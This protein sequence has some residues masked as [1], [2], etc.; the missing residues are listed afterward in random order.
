MSSNSPMPGMF[1]PSKSGLLS[2]MKGLEKISADLKNER[3]KS[4]QAL[5]DRARL[6]I[7][8]QSLKKRMETTLNELDESNRNNRN[9]EED[10]SMLKGRISE[11]E[12]SL[13]T[14]KKELS[15]ME[16][17]ARE[18]S[19]RIDEEVK[20][21]G[22]LET[23]AEQCRVEWRKAQIASEEYE[24]RLQQNQSM[25][26]ELQAELERAIRLRDMSEQKYEHVNTIV[27]DQAREMNQLSSQMAVNAK[28]ATD[29]AHMKRSNDDLKNELK[30]S[31]EKSVLQ[32]NQIHSLSAELNELKNTEGLLN[33]Q[34]LSL[35]LEK[36]KIVQ[37]HRSSE[38]AF[39]EMEKRLKAELDA[40]TA[41]SIRADS[42]I[43]SRNALENQVD[44]LKFAHDAVLETRNRLETDLGAKNK[45]ENS[46]REELQEAKERVMKLE[47][48]LQE[49]EGSQQLS[50]EV[51][52]LRAQLTDLRR[53]LT[54]REVEDEASHITPSTFVEREEQ[55]RRMYEGIISDLRGEVERVA[56]AHQNT[57]TKLE[58]ASRKAALCDQL[59]EQVQIYKE[60]AKMSAVETY[61]V[62][63]TASEAQ[64][65]SQR[66]AHEKEASQ[67]ELRTTKSE[68]VA[69]RAE[70]VR[71]RDELL[72]ER[73]VTRDRQLE[74][75]SSER[76][77]A[78]LIAVKSRLET[79]L[80]S[81]SQDLSRLASANDVL[82]S[83][84]RELEVSLS[85]AKSNLARANQFKSEYSSLNERFAKLE[86]E[87]K[88][89]ESY[90]TA[91]LN[92]LNQT[93]A[94]LTKELE[95]AQNTTHALRISLDD[96]NVT[97][98]GLRVNLGDTRR[99]RDTLTKSVGE[100]ERS[101]A[102]QQ[103]SSLRADLSAT[104]TS[105][106]NAE[107]MRLEKDKAMHN[108]RQEI[109]REK[110]RSGLLKSQVNLLENRLRTCLQELGVYRTLDVYQSGLN[111]EMTRNNYT[112]DSYSPNRSYS[113][114][115]RDRRRAVSL[116][117]SRSDDPEL[118]GLQS[119]LAA[120]ENKEYTLS[121]I[122]AYNE[123][124]NDNNNNNNSSGDT[125]G[126]HHSTS[127][128]KK[129]KI[130]NEDDELTIYDLHLEE[131][132]T[133]TNT[134]NNGDT[135]N[136]SNIDQKKRRESAASRARR[137]VQDQDDDDDDDDAG[138][139]DRIDSNKVWEEAD[140]DRLDGV[141]KGSDNEMSQANASRTSRLLQ[142]DAELRERI[143]SGSSSGTGTSGTG[144]GTG[145]R[146]S[147]NSGSRLGLSSR[148]ENSSRFGSQPASSSSYSSSSSRK[149]SKMD[150]ERAKRL[151]GQ[152]RP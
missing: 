132:G 94:I 3:D 58:E 98:D 33:K 68:L 60:S 70:A 79:S 124:V 49:N 114:T 151:L 17:H 90:L 40:N 141:N 130:N 133:A 46:L 27:Q 115:D 113:N 42:A 29:Y 147:G 36:D 100:R 75:L 69:A 108:I 28:I 48:S 127:T 135:E 88:L 144:S 148:L 87:S 145:G 38:M 125:E 62:A 16:D 34:V 140:D 105:W 83:Q 107:E 30:E 71:L 66:I 136:T 14:Q 5:Q 24:L 104:V 25:I 150:F 57:L 12:D 92:S 137:S 72:T 47:S 22:Q 77:A 118:H 11:L 122:K 152:N 32:T 112:G 143:L 64:G 45:L 121:Q 96:A 91:E 9:L 54:K 129:D 67:R 78:E 134:G 35:E 10:K 31:V 109:A 73:Q 50:I 97:I 128:K 146:Y 85:D 81:M 106:K 102:E 131:D 37:E 1:S 117:Q 55:N 76:K 6:R 53:Q 120:L 56:A 4:T 111:S 80:D 138:N 82:S 123:S 23:E 39:N 20:A 44:E 95:S 18:S 2:P 13:S 99:E 21:R 149:P 142:R 126:D 116:S 93:K 139:T 101:R 59:E 8:L 65:R 86:G 89:K 52:F 51:E 110:E 84:A 74:K 15:E 103:L 43:A 26:G 61:T 63:T 7:E 19:K 119:Q 41:A